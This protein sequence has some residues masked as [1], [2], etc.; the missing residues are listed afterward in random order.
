MVSNAMHAV[1]ASY[2][3]G[4]SIADIRM[5]LSGFQAGYESTPGRLN[6]FDELPFRIIMDFAHNPDGMRRVGEFAGQQT[7][8][9]RKLIAFSGASNRVDKTIRNMGRAVAGYFDF[10]FCKEYEP[11]EGKQPGQVAPILRQGLIEQGVAENQIALKTF[12]KEVI[13]EIFDTCKPGDLLVMLMGHVEKHK[14]PAYI[15]EYADVMRR[16]ATKQT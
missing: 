9:G 12:G 14:L 4:I 13:F 8:P 16:R 1:T 15:Q 11:V 10:Y 5:A 6:I 2:L 7:V 3:S